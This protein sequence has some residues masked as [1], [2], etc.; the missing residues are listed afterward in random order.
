MASRS[1]SSR[2]ALIRITGD[3]RPLVEQLRGPL[4]HVL[5][6]R[7]R[8]YSVRVES[9]GRVGEVMVCIEGSGGRLPL[10]FERGVEPA[11]VGR[12]VSETMDRFGI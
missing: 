1:V 10:I 12:V 8:A 4:L 6:G 9:L 2:A 5:G 11:Y 3:S 7:Q